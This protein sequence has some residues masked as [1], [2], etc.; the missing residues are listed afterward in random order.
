MHTTLKIIKLLQLSRIGI[1]MT[2]PFAPT[3]PSRFSKHN[4]VKV[5]TAHT[6]THTHM[7][8]ISIFMPLFAG[9]SV[10]IEWKVNLLRA[11]SELTA[12]RHC[13]WFLF[14]L[15]FC[16]LQNCSSKQLISFSLSQ[17]KTAKRS[18]DPAWTDMFLVQFTPFLVHTLGH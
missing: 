15:H 10:R 6:Y 5:K 18:V 2:P 9:V 17:S 16:F 4:C 12:A 11:F 1:L 13:F 3:P 7:Y 14:F 8:L